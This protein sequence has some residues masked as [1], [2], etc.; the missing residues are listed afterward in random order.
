M[1][2]PAERNR[3]SASRNRFPGD[4]LDGEVTAQQERAV[5]IRSD[6]RRVVRLARERWSARL[7]GAGRVVLVSRHRHRALL[8]ADGDHPNAAGHKIV[9]KTV[10]GYLEPLL[11]APP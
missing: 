1:P 10:L 9:A 7:A 2:A 5:R 8:P 11:G 4:R 6:D 3:L